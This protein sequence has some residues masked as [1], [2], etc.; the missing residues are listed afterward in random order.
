MIGNDIVDLK[1]AVLDTNWKR[2]RFLDKVFTEEEQK[3]INSS[4]N[5]HQTV[6]LLWSMKEAVYKIYVQQYGNRFFNPK[7]LECNILSPQK[8][9]VLIGEN[10]YNTFFEITEYYIYTIATLKQECDFESDCF[11]VENS[12]YK[13]QSTALQK[14]FFNYLN[15]DG[16]KII[17]N[18]LG[19]PKLFQNDK[20]LNRSFSFTHHGIYAAYV[21]SR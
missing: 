7:R 9:I 3:I 12:T 1:R 17:K 5:Q 11:K 13:T 10:A 14:R 18:D 8:A 2:P 4:E 16:L 21:I 19:V 20:E 15:L 6:W